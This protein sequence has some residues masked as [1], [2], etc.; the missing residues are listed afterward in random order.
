MSAVSGIFAKE[1]GYGFA[2]A[3]AQDPAAAL[4][5]RRPQPALTDVD[6]ALARDAKDGGEGRRQAEAAPVAPAGHQVA[7]VP[8]SE[9]ARQPATLRVRTAVTTRAR[10]TIPSRRHS[11]VGRA[12]VL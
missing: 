5:A 10:G 4:A 7:G 12:A 6:A 3:A 2:F 1:T 9:F 11:S 8:L